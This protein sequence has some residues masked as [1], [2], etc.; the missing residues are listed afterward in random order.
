M[1][2]YNYSAILRSRADSLR[3]H[4]ILHEWL[5][6]FSAFLNIHRSGVLTTLAWLVPRETAAILAQVLSTPYNHAPC[7]F[8]QSHIRKVYACLAVTCHLHFWQYDRDLL[9]ATAVTRVRFHWYVDTEMAIKSTLKKIYVC[10]SVRPYVRKRTQKRYP[11]T[12][13]CS[14]CSS[15]QTWRNRSSFF[16]SLPAF[17]LLVRCLFW[18]HWYVLKQIHCFSATTSDVVQTKEW[19]NDW[20]AL[21]VASFPTDTNSAWNITLYTVKRTDELVSTHAP[22]RTE[23]IVKEIW[24]RYNRL[25]R[26]YIVNYV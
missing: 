4:V 17:D 5:A 19:M 11:V 13:T 7:R 3:S 2:A 8:M 6:L 10:D 15:V 22:Q 16:C 24:T 9:R 20:V 12:E 1:I 23:L 26:R 14:V 18:S 25:H 21:P